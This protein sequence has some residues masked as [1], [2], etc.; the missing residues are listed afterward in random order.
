MVLFT[1]NRSYP[2]SEP[3]DP[4]DVPAALQAFAEAVDND[5]ETRDA[6][7]RSRPYAKVRGATIQSTPANSNDSLRWDI[8]DFDND[9]MV[10]LTTDRFNVYIR[11]A[12][13]YWV[14]GRIRM[15]AQSPTPNTYTILIITK[16]GITSNASRE[17]TQPISPNYLDITVSAL[18]PFSP[19]DAIALRLIHGGTTINLSRFRDLAVFK[20]AT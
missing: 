18:A 6:V 15:Y 3:T 9:D 11:T 17:H 12:G 16:N 1:P 4:A 19:G 5:L 14:W 13:L 10:D 7:I 2:Y 8:E 20:V